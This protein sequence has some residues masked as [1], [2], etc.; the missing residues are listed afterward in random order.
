MVTM[1][2]YWAVAK[3]EACTLHLQAERVLTVA[4]SYSFGIFFTLPLIEE[5]Q[6]VSYW[7]NKPR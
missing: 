2:T 4:C 3:S 1:A 5:E 6:I 7:R